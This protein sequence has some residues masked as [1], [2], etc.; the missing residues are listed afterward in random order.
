M[1]KWEDQEDWL[2]PSQKCFGVSK[3]D[4]LF[5]LQGV[6]NLSIK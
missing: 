4:K 3:A 5:I 2:D 6:T 1:M